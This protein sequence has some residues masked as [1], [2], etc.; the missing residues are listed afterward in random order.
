MTL[1]EPLKVI[2]KLVEVFEQLNIVYFVSG[3]LASSL[4]GIPR[5]TQDVDIVADLKERHIHQLVNALQS[6]FHISTEL[7]QEAIQ[8]KSSFNLIDLETLFKIDIF[9]LSEDDISQ[10]EMNRRKKYRVSDDP[11]QN[12]FI[13]SAEDVILHKLYW[14]QLSGEVS[15]K[16]WSDVLGV[17]QVQ[18]DKLNYS[19]LNQNARKRGVSIL[20]KRAIEEANI[21]EESE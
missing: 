19:Y 5:A 16:Q 10:Q 11:V 9:I 21:E 4:H 1:A 3:S 14:F 13:A 8:S 6:R 12:L 2:Q 7:I 15:E 18:S 20:L 17:L